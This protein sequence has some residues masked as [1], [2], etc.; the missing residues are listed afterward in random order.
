MLLAKIAALCA[1]YVGVAKVGLMLD[2]VSGFATLVWAPTGISLAALLLL[3]FRLSPGVFLGAFL[4]NVWVGAPAAVA[5]GIALGNT[6]EAVVGAYALRRMTGFEREFDHLRHVMGLIVPVAMLSTLISASIGVASLTLGGIVSVHHF[7][8]TWKA[9]WVGDMLGDL[10]VAPLLLTLATVDSLKIKPARLLEATGLGAVLVAASLL[11]FFRRSTGSNPFESP[12]VLFPLFVWAALRFELRGATTA[13]ALAS[14][15]AIWGTTRSSG[16]F[17]RDTLAAS[18]LALQ[19]FMGCAALT[20]LVVGGAISD[21]ARAIRARDNLMATVTHDLKSPISAI[22]MSAD[23]LLTALPTVSTSRVQRHG[24]LVERSVGRMMRLIG[25]LLDAAS[26]DAGR[27]AIER[28]E[29]DARTLV[30]EAVD[31]LRPL[32]VAKKQSLHAD[33]SEP[34][35]VMCDHARM[36]QVL[37]NLIGNAIKFT[38]DGGAI[39]VRTKRLGELVQFSVEDTGA[40][41]EPRH[42]RRVFD[43]YWRANGATGSGTGLGLCIAKGIVEANGGRMWADSMVGVGSKFHFTLPASEGESNRTAGAERTLRDRRPS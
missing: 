43:R 40:G 36:L 1:V 9:W 7:L 24:Y 13:T 8:P 42:L 14:G 19:T 30:S 27:L 41:I 21:R 6:L 15:L 35:H 5:L 34:S 12:Y 38:P 25:D 2:A 31:I 26:I 3:G 20:P 18:L 32:A 22:W 17:A 39:A 16:P 29:E 10:E 23:A 11:V 28:R 4:V 33:G 37:S